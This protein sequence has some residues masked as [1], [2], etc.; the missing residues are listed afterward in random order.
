[1]R[2][3]SWLHWL[4]KKE[5]AM[6]LMGG[7]EGWSLW[8]DISISILE[9]K[10]EG[11]PLRNFS[12]SVWRS[13]KSHWVKSQGEQGSTSSRTVC[14]ENDPQVVEWCEMGW[15]GR[16]EPTF[17]KCPGNILRCLDF[18]PRVRRCYCEICSLLNSGVMFCPDTRWSQEHVFVDSVM[19][20]SS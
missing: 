3:D 17:K 12:A 9:R 20:W 7:D 19:P 6:E 15:K 4:L 16:E 2:E 18:A 10:V 11:R 13:N 5:A 1:M 14:P 8:W